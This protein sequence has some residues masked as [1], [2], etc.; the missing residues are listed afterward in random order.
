MKNEVICQQL[1]NL[2]SILTR[3]GNTQD[4]A[5]SEIVKWIHYKTQPN[6][7]HFWSALMALRGERRWAYFN[8]IK[9]KDTILSVKTID[10]FSEKIC[11]MPLVDSN[12]KFVLGYLE[13][14]KKDL[15]AGDVI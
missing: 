5:L 12:I 3:S 14:C 8:K 10:E 4:A 13:Q 2:C 15:T 6:E 7:A 9:G 11:Q 1:T